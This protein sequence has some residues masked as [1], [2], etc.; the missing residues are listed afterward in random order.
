LDLTIPTFPLQLIMTKVSFPSISFIHPC[1]HLIFQLT[2]IGLQSGSKSRVKLC[3]V[4]STMGTWEPQ[5]AWFFSLS[6]GVPQSNSL[7]GIIL[8]MTFPQ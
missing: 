5:L 4:Q 3:H 8:G 1:S 6:S 2:F 7:C